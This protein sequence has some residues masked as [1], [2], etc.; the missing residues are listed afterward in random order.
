MRTTSGLGVGSSNLPSAAA[1]YASKA[2]R[3]FV[4]V[5]RAW[6]CFLAYAVMRRRFTACS[7][8][9]VSL[10]HTIF[11]EEVY[12]RCHQQVAALALKD[13]SLLLASTF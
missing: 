9:D 3:P 13:R 12:L 8:K 2:S 10:S 11:V 5:S 6:P 7:G 1:L 4:A